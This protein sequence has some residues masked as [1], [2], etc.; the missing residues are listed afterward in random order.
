MSVSKSNSLFH[1]IQKNNLAFY[2]SLF[3]SIILFIAIFAY[4][5]IPDSSPNAN[6]Q[7]LELSKLKPGTEISFIRLH[8]TEN[9]NASS[10]FKKL[11]YGSIPLYKEIPFQSIQRRKEGVQIVPYN[12]LTNFIADTLTFQISELQTNKTKIIPTVDPLV[13][14]KRFWFGTDR[15]GRDLLSRLAL[16]LRVSLAVGF[17]AVIISLIIGTFLGS[18]SGYFG[19]KLDSIIVWFINVIW[20]LP[21]LLLIIAITFALGKGFWQ[22][23]IAIGLSMWVEIARVVRGQVMTFKNQEYIEAAKALGYSNFRII[24]YHLL[25][26]IF[27]PVLVISAANFASAILVEAGLSF[28]GLGVPPPVP[29]WGSMIRENYSAIFFDSAYLAILPGLAILMLVLLFMLL[30]KGLREA[31]N[32]RSN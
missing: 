10:L 26:N 20:S 30:G 4:Y 3:I 11:L 18:I 15:F 13:F 24:F 14:K 9:A 7:H 32:V 2:S 16:G 25:P 17:I 1:R 31:L 5:L 8:K 21:S 29:T 19:G 27:S 28:L 22:V 6:N 23:F 12:K